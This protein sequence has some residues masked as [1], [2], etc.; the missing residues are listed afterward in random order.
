VQAVELLEVASKEGVFAQELFPRLQKIQSQ[1]RE[2]LLAHQSGKFGKADPI[3]VDTAMAPSLS[4]GRESVGIGDDD[5]LVMLGAATRLSRKS[6]SSQSPSV[7]NNSISGSDEGMPSP[8]NKFFK[9]TSP[10]VFSDAG[11]S[12][13]K[14][15]VLSEPNFL[16]HR[17]SIPHEQLDPAVL[18][19]VLSADPSILQDFDQTETESKDYTRQPTGPTAPSELQQQP[20]YYPAPPYQMA[21]STP[22]ATPQNTSFS[23]KHTPQDIPVPS[24]A[25]SHTLPMQYSPVS[26][27]PSSSVPN[28]GP[29]ADERSFAYGGYGGYQFTDYGP[30]NAGPVSLMGAAPKAGLGPGFYDELLDSIEQPDNASLLQSMGLGGAG[31]SSWAWSTYSMGEDPGPGQHSGWVDNQERNPG[32]GPT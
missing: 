24:H 19:M 10:L 2:K 30:S 4:L 15:A 32:A 17:N 14:P 28:A 23:G 13:P 21:Y 25:P 12:S 11:R 8:G 16:S 7:T 22:G 27:P 29:V 9:V 6:P 26:A 3:D 18:E 31:S 5:E 20:T 1:V